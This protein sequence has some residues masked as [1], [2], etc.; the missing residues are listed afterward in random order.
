MLKRV[1]TGT[2]LGLVL[3]VLGSVAVDRLLERQARR[4][5]SLIDL[6]FPL[7][8][9]VDEMHLLLLQQQSVIE[10]SALGDGTPAAELEEASGRF[11]EALS[12]CFTVCFSM[13]AQP[14]PGLAPAIDELSAELAPIHRAFKVQSRRI[15]RLFDHLAGHP[16]GGNEEAERL[17]REVAAAAESFQESVAR[18]EELVAQHYSRALARASAER[19]AVRRLFAVLVG[20]AVLLGVLANV[21]FYRSLLPLKSMVEAVRGVARGQYEVRAPAEGGDEV[22]FLA[23]EFN[24]MA[25]AIGEQRSALEQSQRFLR[26]SEK[27]SAIGELSLGVAH[28]VRNPVSTIQMTLHAL[29]KRQDLSRAERERLDLALHEVDRLEGLVSSLLDYGRPSA[30]QVG[31]VDVGALVERSIDLVE[32]ECARCGVTVS[33][34]PAAL[35]LPSIEAD[36]YQ[37]IQV[38]VNLL[39]NAVQASPPGG[40]VRVTASRDGGTPGGEA[41]SIRVLDE[42]AG[43]ESEE[44]KRIFTPFFT[45][46][47]DGTGLGLPV[48]RKI[49]EAHGGELTV[50]STPGRGTAATLRLPVRPIGFGGSED[51]RG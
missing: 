36:G 21:Y 39:L 22:A 20:A 7:E 26:Q 4:Y 1:L 10:R 40:R 38:L 49:A 43:I 37:V 8:E 47:R 31:P 41:V 27:L 28:E 30:P 6:F 50:V 46:R 32:A 2:I 19:S 3:F 9:T 34:E 25:Q 15:E 11:T 42:G 13:L 48:A 12:A 35:G 33:V 16:L 5:Q 29:D 45:T 44:L 14:K 23:D 18:F 17:E 51:V 24:A